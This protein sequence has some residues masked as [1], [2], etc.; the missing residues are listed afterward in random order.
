KFIPP[1]F[2]N[3]KHALK[4]RPELKTRK[5][6]RK[7][8]RL[9]EVYY[10][11]KDMLAREDF[12]HMSQ[13][14][15]L[16]HLS[17]K[18]GVPP[19][20]LKNW[21]VRGT[22]PRLIEAIARDELKKSEAMSGKPSA[23]KTRKKRPSMPQTYE[24]FLG[25]LERHPYLR[26]IE[27]FEEKVRDVRE[28]FRLIELQKK[29]P[30]LSNSELARR[31]DANFDTA[32]IWLSG[33]RPSLI[34]IVLTNEYMR[35]RFENGFLPEF[36]TRL[37]DSSV[38]YRTL[39]PLESKNEQT[40]ENIAK[41]LM[42]LYRD[43]WN[44]EKVIVVPLRPYNEI[45]GPRWLLDLSRNIKRNRSAIEK[46]LCVQMRFGI[47]RQYL[48]LGL[49]S[50][51][52]YFW[53]DETSPFDY[54]E[55][56][57][58][59][60]FFFS[61]KYR[62]TLIDTALKHL[63]LK[64]NY[65]LSQLI[66]QITRYDP[67][68]LSGCGRLIQDLKPRSNLLRGEVLRFILDSQGLTLKD[69]YRKIE[70]VGIGE[71]ILNPKFPDETTLK[72]LLARLYA[73]IG[74]DGSIDSNYKVSHYD[75]VALRRDKLRAMVQVLG[76]INCRSLYKSDGSECG[77]AMPNIVGRLLA[78]VGMPVGDK[79]LQDVRIPEFIMNGSPE[80]QFAYLEELIPD[81]GC[82][83]IDRKDNIRICWGRSVVLYD[84][85]KGKKY[86]LEQKISHQIVEFIEKH[87][88][89]HVRYYPSGVEETY[90]TLSM[91]S[92]K[93]LMSSTKPED[94]A[95]AKELEQV[96]RAN[97][98]LYIEDEK[99][100]C[101]INGIMTSEQS[102]GEI[103]RSISSDRVSV[104]WDVRA[105]SEDDVALWGILAPPNDERKRGRLKGWMKRHPSK[106]KAAQKK[107]YYSMQ[108][109]KRLRNEATAGLDG[110]SM[111]KEEE[112][113]V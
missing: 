81:E 78:R 24:N 106:V 70:R 71:Q 101:D 59:E 74:S 110:E 22:L 31:V 84:A 111:N 76:G 43:Y 19:T 55:L 26:E 69:V 18:Y 87:G 82:V 41:H 13:R 112:N 51:L 27:G 104:K 21:V 83:T 48:R 99:H 36:H 4:E 108:E 46:I 95:K 86:R 11:V 79:V 28:Y 85:K 60:L 8:L 16:R 91:G 42:L 61:D 75:N 93:E 9:A 65:L 40:V 98:S 58:Q 107:L 80:L 113:G 63:G 109:T 23:A 72:I 12:S 25:M 105:S 1:T 67:R 56:F 29:N 96:I 52:L 2:E 92:L 89:R 50:D 39:K 102:P 20:S 103:R 15:M 44:K 14:A 5:D 35:V 62:T 38:V 47:E 53:R 64:G 7:G 77:L 10:K 33:N 97:P 30:H 17:M 3:F 32:R 49:V 54:L 94:A 34:G 57:S 68:G 66:K 90:F 37:V 45:R 6:Y 73:M 100:L 88:T